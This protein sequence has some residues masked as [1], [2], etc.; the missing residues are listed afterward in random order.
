MTQTTFN[1]H[2]HRRI[3][4]ND[5]FKD[6]SRLRLSQRGVEM[7]DHTDIVLLRR[8]VQDLQKIVQ[9]QEDEIAKL[10]DLDTKRMRS[11]VI[12]LGSLLVSMGVYVWAKI[13]EGK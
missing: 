8:D 1:H 5:V 10:K 6:R 7:T 4:K 11:A 12:V 2:S 3:P 9:K 13:V